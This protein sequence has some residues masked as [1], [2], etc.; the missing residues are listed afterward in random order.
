[1]GDHLRLR[2]AVSLV[3]AGAAAAAAAVLPPLPGT[4]LLIAAAALAGALLGPPGALFA[5]PLLLFAGGTVDRIAVAAAGLLAGGALYGWRL[6]AAGDARR[7]PAEPVTRWPLPERIAAITEDWS[8]RTGVGVILHS[9]GLDGTPVDEPAPHVVADLCWILREAL[10][11]VANHARAE[12][13]AVTLGRDGDRLTLEVRDDGAGFAVPQSLAGLR[14]AG[15]RGLAGMDERARLRGGRL[16]LW[17]RPGGG[18]RITAIVPAVVVAGAPQASGRVRLLVGSAAAVVPLVL[19]AALGAP[20]G[21]ATPIAAPD[22]GLPLDPRATHGPATAG[23]QPIAPSP[24]ATS[25]SAAATPSRSPSA[26]ATA[27]SATPVVEGASVTTPAQAR[28]CKVQYVKRTEWNYGFVADVTLTNL[29][30]APLSRWT[31]RFDYT[32]GQ[33]I[34]NYWNATVS[35]N[36]DAVVV[37]DD[38]NHGSLAPGASLTF[39]WQ[40]TWQGSDPAPTGF[41]LDGAPCS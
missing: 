27:G 26:R 40:G 11:N 34:T 32:A 12:T 30:T 19:A 8:E 31:I 28:T 16:D 14:R 1:M 29:G 41:T 10:D 2:L 4:A 36:G 23:Q 38:G 25:G 3:A 37:G 21:A 24:A 9:A 6:W 7:P 22:T 18:T 17:S 20:G 35:Q 13:V 15:Q 33:K 39:G 5:V